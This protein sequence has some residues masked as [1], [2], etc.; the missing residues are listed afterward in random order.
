MENKK[1]E[2][3]KEFNKLGNELN[4]IIAK[5]NQIIG[6]LELLDSQEKDRKVEVKK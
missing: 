5:R 2:L 4:E 3:I 1:E 6:K